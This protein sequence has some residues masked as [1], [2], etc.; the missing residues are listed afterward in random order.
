MANSL[1]FRTQCVCISYLKEDGCRAREF[2]Y[3][4]RYYV[5]IEKPSILCIFYRQCIYFCKADFHVCIDLVY[6]RL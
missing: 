3:M 1:I 4:C 6:V 5:I 2:C